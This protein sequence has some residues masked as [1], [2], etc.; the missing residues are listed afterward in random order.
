MRQWFHFYKILGN[1]S[2]IQRQVQKQIS[3]CFAGCLG[4]ETEGEEWQR[5]MRK[6][7]GMMDMFTDLGMMGSFLGV[8]EKN[9]RKQNI[10][11]VS[12][13]K[14]CVFNHKIQEFVINL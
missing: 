7:L 4:E 8:W 3:G 12:K 9:K 11:G 5:G 13:I 2:L 1:A 6:L 14:V 10:G